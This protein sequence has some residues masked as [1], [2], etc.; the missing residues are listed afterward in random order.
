MRASA[1][2]QNR[3]VSKIVILKLLKKLNLMNADTFCERWFGLDQLTNAEKEKAKNAWGYRAKCVRL[4]SSVLRKPE[5]TV[6]KWGSRFERMPKDLESALIY[7]DSIRLQ[8]QDLPRN[9]L[10]LYL[11][12]TEEN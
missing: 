2:S 7:A 5:N 8:I 11:E 6:D 12:R 4:L 1:Y 9:L 3:R 10:N